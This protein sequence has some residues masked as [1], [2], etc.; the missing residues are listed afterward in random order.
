MSRR[1]QLRVYVDAQ[2]RTLNGITLKGNESSTTRQLVKDIVR[3]L[4]CRSTGCDFLTCM[5]EPPCPRAIR[6]CEQ[7]VTIVAG[8][9][10][11]PVTSYFLHPPRTL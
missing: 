10:H 2:W 11:G 8:V 1:C 9:S 7:P 6:C 3:D 4:E 5:Q